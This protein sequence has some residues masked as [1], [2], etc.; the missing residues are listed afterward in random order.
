MN[1]VRQ[2]I[3]EVKEML[4]QLK[5]RQT[6][7]IRRGIFTKRRRPMPEEDHVETAV[8]AKQ[9]L[10]LDELLPLLPHLGGVIPQLKNPKVQETIKILS[11]PAVAGMIQQFVANGGLNALKGKTYTQARSRSRLFRR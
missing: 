11:N 2:E 10:P 3:Q 8:K 7:P 4:D 1:S 9:T 6:R 5:S